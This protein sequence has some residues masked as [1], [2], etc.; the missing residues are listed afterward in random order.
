M[1]EE[2]SKMQKGLRMM[3]QLL[4]TFHNHLR[5]G[6]GVAGLGLHLNKKAPNGEI[7]KELLSTA[8]ATMSL[9]SPSI[10]SW[11]YIALQFQKICF[12]LHLTQ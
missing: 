5:A 7:R 1:R 3:G 2:Q 6:G 4:K 11:P 12:L 9:L 8:I 10:C